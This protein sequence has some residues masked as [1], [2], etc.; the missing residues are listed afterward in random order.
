MGLYDNWFLRAV[1]SMVLQGTYA[2]LNKKLIEDRGSPR[3]VQVVI[4]LAVSLL[5]MLAMAWEDTVHIW[6]LSMVAIAAVQGVLF[7]LTTAMRMNAL[8]CGVPAHIVFPIV[9]SSVVFIIVLSAF[10]FDGWAALQ[11]SLRLAGVSLAVVATFILVEWRFK[12]SRQVLNR[13]VAYA[14]LAMISGG[15]A[16]LMA[17]YLF[18]A[19]QKV[20]IFH[21]M[22]ISN[23]VTMLLALLN[24]WRSEHTRSR[25]VYDYSLFWG[26]LMGVLSFGGFAAFLQAI[27]V[28]DLS[29][30]ASIN[31]MSIIIP[32]LLAAWLYGEHL[33]VRKEIAVL[34]SVV[35]LV[36][37]S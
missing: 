33:S 34:L 19:D 35:A 24:F 6:Y 20:S 9:K 17:K 16:S 30:V 13:G 3:L 8:A 18:V 31:A 32:V 21:F 25:Q 4:P 1:V 27:K 11:E 37:I 23:L 22:L 10:L 28:G 2:F 5:S 29:V 12:T 36:L 14:L 26:M 7:F 15:G